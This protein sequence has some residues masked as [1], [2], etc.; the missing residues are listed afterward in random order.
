MN[1]LIKVIARF[2]GPVCARRLEARDRIPD[3]QGGCPRSEGEPQPAASPQADGGTVVFGKNTGTRD[4]MP[5]PAVGCLAGKP[6]TF[7]HLPLTWADDAPVPFRLRPWARAARLGLGTTLAPP[8][9]YCCRGQYTTP[10]EASS[11]ELL[12]NP[13]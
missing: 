8:V 6:P 13:L 4:P 12:A 2:T 3:E 11:A 5:C 1:H 9:E 7:G 10:G